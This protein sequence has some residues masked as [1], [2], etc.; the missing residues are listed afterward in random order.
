MSGLRRRARRSDFRQFERAGEASESASNGTLPRA[1]ERVQQAQE[2]F[3]L[4][5]GDGGSAPISARIFDAPRDT[6]ISRRV[7]HGERLSRPQQFKA[8]RLLEIKAPRRVLFCARRQV[9]KEVLFARKVAGRRGG[10]PGRRGRYLRNANS[11]WR[12]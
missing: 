10:S 4:P 9:R 11:Q 7:T 8:L 1:Q 3:A 12:C 2:R 5:W 6:E